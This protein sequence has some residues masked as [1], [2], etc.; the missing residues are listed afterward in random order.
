[1]NPAKNRKRDDDYAEELKDFVKK[2]NSGDEEAEFDQ[3]DILKTV[4]TVLSLSMKCNN[5]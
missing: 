2:V 1:M 3:D 4:K 5:H